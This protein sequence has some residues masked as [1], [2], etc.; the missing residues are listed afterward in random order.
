MSSQPDC[1][2]RPTLTTDQVEMDTSTPVAAAPVTGSSST[3]PAVPPMTAEFFLKALKDNSDHIIKSFNASLGAL[4]QRIDDNAGKIAANS[5]SITSLSATSDAHK[6]ELAHLS[7]RVA[8]LE[9]GES[10]AVVP[11]Q[12]A[13][14]SPEYLFARCLVR[15]W[16]ISGDT[17]EEIW[18]SVGEFLHDTL[19][20]RED[21][22]CQDD[23]EVIDRVAAG[24]LAVDRKEV[25]V[26]FFDKQKRDS[27]MSS[28]S[29]LASKVD[30]DGKPTAGIRLEIP[31]E[32]DGTFRLLSRFGT[33]LSQF[34][35]CLDRLKRLGA[36]EGSIALVRAFLDGRTMTVTIN[37]YAAK[38]I[39]ITRGSPQGSVL[40][41]LLYC[42]AT[43]LLTLALRAS[44]RLVNYFPQD[45]GPDHGVEFWE[46]D[47]SASFL[48][49]DDTTLLDAVPLSSAVRHCT[50]G[51]TVE[52]F[53][54]LAVAGDFNKLSRRAE[55]IGMA[56]NGSKTQLLVISPP[57]AVR[58][59]LPSPLLAATISSLWKSLNWS[60]SCSAPRP[61]PT[62]MLKH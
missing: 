46:R 51:T 30:L 37:G 43:Q 22:L 3:M 8:V 61:G 12:R 6:T 1:P 57:M 33:R 41:C 2:T 55:D 47:D 49:V 58:R 17:D 44:Q 34:A 18:E 28:S 5:T 45:E 23:I 53:W 59:P 31:P 29:N 36:S 10:A 21:D 25:L 11:D 42:V 15:L 26:S 52:E 60:V 39:V 50:T 32:L 40:G 9:R 20:I 4:S 56:I 16:P 38:P 19:A 48:Y 7:D 54:Q 24:R 27:V 62:P 35:V 13:A 14:L